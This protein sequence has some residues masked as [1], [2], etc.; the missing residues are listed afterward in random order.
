[1]NNTVKEATESCFK[2]EEIAQKYEWKDVE[3]YH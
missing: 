3:Y 2:F 1:M